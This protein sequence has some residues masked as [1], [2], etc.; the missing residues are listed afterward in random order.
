MRYSLVRYVGTGTEGDLFRPAG[1]NA[2]PDV[3]AIDLRPDSTVVDGFALLAT[4]TPPPTLL[5]LVDSLGDDLNDLSLANRLLLQSKLG[6][7]L[8]AGRPLRRLIRDILTVHARTDGTRWKP[9]QPELINGRARAWR[10]RLGGEVIDEVPVVEGGATISESFDKANSDTLGPDLTWTE[11]AGD[12]DIVGN[13]AQLQSGVSLRCAARAETQ[14]DTVDH[15]AQVDC[16][17]SASSVADIGV[18]V[19][20]AAAANTYYMLGRQP[21]GDAKRIVKMVAGTGTLIASAAYTDDDGNHTVY[22]SVNGSSLRLLIDGANELTATDTEIT[23]GRRCGITGVRL[24]VNTTDFDNFTAA[25]LGVTV[26]GNQATETDTANVGA[27]AVALP[28]SQATETDTANAG[29]ATVTVAG[30]LATETA[31]ANAGTPLVALAG[32]QADETDTPN[33]GTPTVTVAG[34]LATETDT[35]NA[36]TAGQVITGNLAT[37]SDT[38]NP[39]SILVTVAGS[40]AVETDS[41]LVGALLVA[42]AGAT[43]AETDAALAGLPTFTITGGQATETDTANGGT[44]VGGAAAAVVG[45]RRGCEPA[46]PSPRRGLAAAAASSRRGVDPAAP[47]SRRDC[48]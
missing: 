39:G 44:P 37:E 23:T 25:D 26:A 46:D 15:Y 14:L 42:L 24:T 3:T 10:I 27:L 43:A 5:G 29:T 47:S 30:A 22:G 21:T 38:A 18:A 13:K 12:F 33:P 11:V 41:P 9:L 34:D 17:P 4:P 36:G 31:T 16:D 40:Q 20:F 8:D 7:T 6:I 35:A 32:G 19:R 48:P 1:I 45:N 2:I 28:G